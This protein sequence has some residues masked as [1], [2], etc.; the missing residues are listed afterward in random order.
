MNA[1]SLHAS[2]D[3]VHVTSFTGDPTVQSLIG[4]RIARY[5]EAIGAGNGQILAVFLAEAILIAC[6]GGLLGLTL[7]WS[8][9]WVLVRLYPVFPAAIPVWAVLAALATSVCLGALFG[10]LPARRAARLDPVAALAGR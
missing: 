10:V 1:D 6:L 2:P 5:L 9:I 7:G 4:K 8:S 3:M